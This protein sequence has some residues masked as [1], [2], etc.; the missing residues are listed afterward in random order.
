MPETPFADTIRRFH[1]A[2]VRFVV[3]GGV[4]MGLHGSSYV[5][6]D[7]DFAYAVEPENVERLA[8]LLAGIHARVLGRPA[9]DGFVID[10]AILQRVRFL[11]LKTD[12]GEVDVLRE[13]GGIDS[14]EGLWDRAVPMD[15]GGFTAQ[16]ASINDLIAMKRAANRLKDQ[17]HLYELL[18]LKKLL[19][20]EGPSPGE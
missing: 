20:G 1:E 16:I 14:F 18:A 15:L 9:G 13:I 8:A 19:E 11:N 17:N 5:T 7:V 4:A 12:M 2:G 3:I 10:P 6:S